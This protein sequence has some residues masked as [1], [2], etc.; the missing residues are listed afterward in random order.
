MPCQ[1]EAG[2]RNIGK[3][4]IATPAVI[5]IDDLKAN[6]A[7]DTKT[8]DGIKAIARTPVG[9][10]TPPELPDHRICIGKLK[11]ARSDVTTNHS[12]LV[13]Y[14]PCGDQL[15]ERKT[16]QLKP[17]FLAPIPDGDDTINTDI[18]IAGGV[19]C[20]VCS[21][22]ILE[23]SDTNAAAPRIPDDFAGLHFTDMEQ[24]C[25]TLAYATGVWTPGETSRYHPYEAI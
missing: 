14:R 12:G 16:T 8:E 10:S 17:P 4:P 20:D 21:F 5:F 15:G 25:R 11:S 6:R 2:S 3:R 18:P 13:E 22:D 1:K 7:H 19:G 9:T 24:D 23:R